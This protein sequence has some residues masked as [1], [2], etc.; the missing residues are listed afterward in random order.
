MRVYYVA[1]MFGN[2]GCFS[3][4]FKTVKIVSNKKKNSYF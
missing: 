4:L 1:V 3:V 2:T